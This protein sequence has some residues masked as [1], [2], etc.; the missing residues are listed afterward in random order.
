M[1]F[2]FI[3]KIKNI[4]AREIMDS[5]GKPT[6][7]VDVEL[8]SGCV[9]RAS[10]PSGAST[11]IYEAVELRDGDVERCNGF[12]VLKAVGNVNTEIKEAVVGE[13]AKNQEEIDGILVNLD[14]SYNKS[15]LGANAILGT[16]LAVAKAEA[17]EENVGLYKY[18]GGDEARVLPVPMMNILNGG[19]HADNLLDFQEFMI[20]PVKAENIRHAICIGSEIFYTLKSNLMKKG[21]ST[22][23]G[24][25]GGF[26][27]N[28]K[29]AREAINLIIEAINDAGYSAGD[30]VFFGY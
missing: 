12:G 15:R 29:T 22:N 8:E 19:K 28:L 13:N 1:L 3:I 18:L 16:S 17:K 4:V 2:P 25:E 7:E 9:G 6:V 20:L 5:R 24:D 26:A 10:V 23:V 27:P 11:G 30:D 14:G 21:F